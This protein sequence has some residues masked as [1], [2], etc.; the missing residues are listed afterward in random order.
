MLEPYIK[1]RCEAFLNE[2]VKK[3]APFRLIGFPE[4][5]D[6]KVKLGVGIAL[7]SCGL[8]RMRRTRGLPHRTFL[9]AGVIVLNSSR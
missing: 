1:R 2:M 7:I 4:D 3:G 8:D 5:D 9:R 6:D